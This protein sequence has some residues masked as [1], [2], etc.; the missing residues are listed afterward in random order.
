MKKLTMTLV[1]V[2]VVTA[3][4]TFAFAY[5][6]GW[7]RGHGG[8]DCY[9]P[10]TSYLSRLNLTPEQTAK[11]NALREAYLKDTK[12]LTDRMFSK[13]GDL[14]LLWLQTNPDQAKIIATQKEIRALRDQ[15]Q[16]KMT[17]YRLDVLKVL[18]PAQQEQ[19]KASRWGRGFGPG[20][21]GGGPGMGPGMGGGPGFGGGPG[22]RGNW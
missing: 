17:A 9:G 14:K 21:K 13:R 20:M 1:A 8:A 4:A 12:P 18:T 3:L 6:P 7:G 19:L 22:M 10:D 11:V 5:G 16:D 2:V 15:M